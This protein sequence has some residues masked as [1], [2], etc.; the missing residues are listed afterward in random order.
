MASF[1]TV[2]ELEQLASDVRGYATE[3]RTLGY[4][5]VA[6]GDENPFLE[7]SDRMMR[8]VDNVDLSHKP[9][10]RETR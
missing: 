5:P 6:G 2:D 8:R 7:L 3:V 10:R 4:S 1:Q 9:L